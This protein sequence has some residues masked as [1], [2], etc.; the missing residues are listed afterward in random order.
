MCG[1]CIRDSIFEVIP[2]LLLWYIH[3]LVDVFYI[4]SGFLLYGT[5]NL[6]GRTFPILCSGLISSGLRSR[7]ICQ[8]IKEENRQINE[9]ILNIKVMNRKDFG[10]VET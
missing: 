2:I 8:K 7:Q 6:K 4:L 1:P 5:E 10:T 9:D 3:F